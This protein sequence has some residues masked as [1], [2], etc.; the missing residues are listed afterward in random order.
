MLRAWGII[1]GLLFIA[2]IA[3]KIT[4]FDAPPVMINID[5][6]KQ[7]LTISKEYDAN[8]ALQV[9]LKNSLFQ[10]EQYMEENIAEINPESIFTAAEFGE[11]EYRLVGLTQDGEAKSALFT[12]NLTGEEEILSIGNSLSGWTLTEIRAGRAQLTRG[13]DLMWVML[14]APQGEP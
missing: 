14:Y 7:H 3:A 2:I 10:S 4:K 1:C 13:A 5:T 12:N 9:L 8:T 6:Q 11:F